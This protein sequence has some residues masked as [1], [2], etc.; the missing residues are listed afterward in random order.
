[1]KSKYVIIELEG[2]EVP[3]VFPRYLLHENVAMSL[4]NN[5]RSAGFC[6]LNLAGKWVASGQSVSLTLSA[7]PQDTEILNTL[8]GMGNFANCKTSRPTSSD[9]SK[10]NACI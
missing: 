3:L 1:M 4:K 9:A 10:Q 2:M 6:E 7:R 8:L 5:I